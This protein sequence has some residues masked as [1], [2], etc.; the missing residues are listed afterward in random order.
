[1]AISTVVTFAPVR[2]CKFLSADFG[3]KSLYEERLTEALPTA[4]SHLEIGGSI[5]AVDRA[6]GTV[7]GAKNLSRVSTNRKI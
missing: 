1:M 6:F 7:T 5:K 2:V 4:M 3:L